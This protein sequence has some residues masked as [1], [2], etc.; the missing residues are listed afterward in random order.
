[1]V[2][3]LIPVLSPGLEMAEEKAIGTN[4][5]GVACGEVVRAVGP[6]PGRQPPGIT[7]HNTATDQGGELGFKEG[8]VDLI[9]L[10]GTAA[11]Q[12]N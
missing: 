12:A 7:V 9:E 3:R 6:A 11:N 5:E 10:Q 1:M 8:P 2:P 4:G